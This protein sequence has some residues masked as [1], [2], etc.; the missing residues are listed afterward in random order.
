M[1]LS[2]TLIVEER[3]REGPSGRRGEAA[4][5]SAGTLRR[6]RDGDPRAFKEIFAHYDRRLRG[7]ASRVLRDPQ[8][9]DDAMQ[10]AAI[11]AFRGLPQFREDASLGTWLYRITYTTCLNYLRDH[12]PIPG[13]GIDDDEGRSVG[14]DDPSELATA[15]LDLRDTLLRLTPQQRVAVLLVI[16]QGYDVRTAA[17]ILGIPAGT[18]ASRLA[19]ARAALRRALSAQ[20]GEGG[21]T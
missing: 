11:K 13:I 15:V 18:M 16:Q 19:A 3:G 4:D 17:E 21:K 7:L 5:V 6:A 14:L 10:E 12:G 2:N 9:M 8:A 1:G 20:P